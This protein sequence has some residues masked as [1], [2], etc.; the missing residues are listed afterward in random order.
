MQRDGQLNDPQVGCQVTTV[1]TDYFDYFLSQF[2]RK[3]VE[4]RLSELF[5][6]I[7]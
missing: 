7:G 3:L 1:G 4:L 2:L 6:I 5:Y